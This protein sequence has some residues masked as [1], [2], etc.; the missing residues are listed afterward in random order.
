[1]KILKKLFSSGSFEV[2]D[3][4]LFN[5]RLSDHRL[6]MLAA[7]AQY[8]PFLHEY[9]SD[10]IIDILTQ[11]AAE[12]MGLTIND[13][14]E[15]SQALAKAPI[16]YT[17]CTIPVSLNRAADWFESRYGGY[18]KVLEG[19]WNSTVFTATGCE[20]LFHVTYGREG[21]SGWVNVS[22]FPI[23]SARFSFQPIIAIDLLSPSE[24]QAI[25][26]N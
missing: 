2:D 16:C 7:S 23:K 12:K 11:V 6:R 17:V 3:K 15:H 24:K 19:L 8:A 26:I 13:K 10:D 9:L 14:K 25:G 20:V 1:M 4:K 22:V 18:F 21:K 5:E